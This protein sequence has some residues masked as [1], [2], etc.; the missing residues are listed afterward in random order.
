[1]FRIILKTKMGDVAIM[2]GDDGVVVKLIKD[3]QGKEVNT[4]MGRGN[5]VTFDGRMINVLSNGTVVDGHFIEG[6]KIMEFQISK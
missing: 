6:A 5:A 3:S 2:S 1:M 4:A